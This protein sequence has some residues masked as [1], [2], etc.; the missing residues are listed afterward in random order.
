M[1]TN[2]YG[3]TCEEM[4]RDLLSQIGI[5]HKHGKGVSRDWYWWA[6]GFEDRNLGIDCWIT[7]DLHEFAVDF[8]VI[9][10]E[11]QMQVKAS[12]ALD[13]GVIPVFLPQGMVRRASEGDE[14]ALSQFSAEIKTQ[15]KV[16]VGLLN[17]KMMTRELAAI[18]REAMR[19]KVLAPVTS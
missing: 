10:G 18:M 11:G 5:P 3:F 4:I 9:S 7:L 2:S 16:K 14:R 15:I 17:G 1:C 13:R 8:T 19:S 12:K 6:S